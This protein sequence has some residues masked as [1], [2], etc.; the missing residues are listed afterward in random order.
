MDM[1]RRQRRAAEAAARTGQLDDATMNQ[2][3]HDLVATVKGNMPSGWDVT[4]IVSRHYGDGRAD[5]K[6]ATSLPPQV[7]RAVLEALSA[8]GGPS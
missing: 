5:V 3:V 4:L 8:E 1:N 7:E 2:L 6:K